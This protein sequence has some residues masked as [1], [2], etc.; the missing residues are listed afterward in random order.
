MCVKASGVI[1]EGL[2]SFPIVEEFEAKRR[3]I[4]C[5][6]YFKLLKLTVILPLCFITICKRL[7]MGH[8]NF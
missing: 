2:N 1:W 4:R 8:S 5:A 7:G 6:V 3:G